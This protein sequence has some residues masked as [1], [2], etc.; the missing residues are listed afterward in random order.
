MTKTL[1]RAGSLACALILA[2]GRALACPPATPAKPAKPAAAVE[3]SPAEKPKSKQ[4]E[5]TIPW[6]EAERLKGKAEGAHRD[7]A[8]PALKN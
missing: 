5:M 6:R 8:K 3:W 2:Q 7:K 1:L 4:F